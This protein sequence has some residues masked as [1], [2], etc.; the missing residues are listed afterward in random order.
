[1]NGKSFGMMKMKIINKIRIK[2]NLKNPMKIKKIK[3]MN[4]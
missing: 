1:M 4:N 2:L 3:K